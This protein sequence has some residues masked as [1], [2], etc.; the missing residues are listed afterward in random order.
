M[1]A[2]CVYVIWSDL[3]EYGNIDWLYIFFDGFNSFLEIIGGDLSIFDDA[4]NNELVDAVGN[5]FLLVFFF[6]DES[7]NLDGLD[8]K[9]EG[10]EVGLGFPRLHVE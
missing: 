6:P 10:V 5:G 9:E 1:F 2:F 7:V 3:A 8:L 4:T